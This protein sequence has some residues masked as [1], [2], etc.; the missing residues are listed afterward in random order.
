MELW[1][2][3][4]RESKRQE[5]IPQYNASGGID[6]VRERQCWQNGHN[7]SR[8]SSTVT[9]PSEKKAVT[10]SVGRRRTT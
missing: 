3:F 10:T 6:P 1:N 7:K 4:V 5:R 9:A 8:G 2:D